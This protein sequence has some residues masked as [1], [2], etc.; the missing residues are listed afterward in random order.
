M[1]SDMAHKGN[2][3]D[4]RAGAV[5]PPEFDQRRP[6]VPYRVR[7]STPRTGSRSPRRAAPGEGRVRYGRGPAPAAVPYACGGA[8]SGRGH[9]D[10]TRLPYRCNNRCTAVPGI[11]HN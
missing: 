2:V 7:G 1:L 10:I 3:P 6:I 4:A 8:F 9:R 5:S 11:L